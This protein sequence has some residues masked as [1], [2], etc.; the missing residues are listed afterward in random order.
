MKTNN[1]ETA[2]PLYEIRGETYC[3]MM[4]VLRMI[5]HESEEAT[6]PSV[7]YVLSRMKFR[8]VRNALIDPNKG[9]I[10][11]NTC[12]PGRYAVG[13]ANKAMIYEFFTGQHDDNGQPIFVS[14]Y[15]KAKLYVTYRDAS[16]AA[17]FMDGYD[18][19][20]LDMYDSLPE[21]VRF[22]RSLLV[23]Y[24]ADEGS[25]NAEIPNDIP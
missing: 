1:N 19:C 5:H 25:E 13:Y 15:T 10:N 18:C 23:S 21:H 4:D 2:L 11:D 17:D 24:D 3:K 20:V 16:A 22:R 14:D 12:I 9:A 6:D 7:R 8:L